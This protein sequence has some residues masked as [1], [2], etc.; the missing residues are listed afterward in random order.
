MSQN[1]P[2]NPDDYIDDSMDDDNIDRSL[3]DDYVDDSLTDGEIDSYPKEQMGY[4]QSIP[5]GATSKEIY[6]MVKRSNDY[7][8]LKAAAQHIMTGLKT[9]EH[10]ASRK[11]LVI[12]RIIA[13]R[14]DITA[15]L[16]DTMAKQHN[17]Y[18][19]YV[20]ITG[21]MKTSRQTLEYIYDNSQEEEVVCHIARHPRC[22]GKFAEKLARSKFM[23]VRGAMAMSKV[24]KA[25]IK[26][27]SRDE[28]SL[29]RRTL[30][31]NKRCPADLTFQIVMEEE[32]HIADIVQITEQMLNNER[33]RFTEK[34]LRI[35]LLSCD[36]YHAAFG[37][38]TNLLK[39][40]NSNIIKKIWDK[41]QQWR[42]SHRT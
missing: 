32:L 2:T 30:A 33:E 35:L 23:T 7:T 36:A 12:N 22:P 19:L 9:L 14:T 13:S 16:L 3:N 6:G 8:F 25:T 17:D 1:F 27:L 26:I 21:N 15:S 11:E 41:L 31:M 34:E 10:I 5:L 40:R 29:V 38:Y 24:S 18:W 28:N 4:P 20:R 42:V 37:T 39:R